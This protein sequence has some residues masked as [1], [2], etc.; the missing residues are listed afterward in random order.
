[1]KAAGKNTRGF[2]EEGCPYC[3]SERLYGPQHTRARFQQKWT[4]VQCEKSFH[5]N[6]LDK[7]YTNVDG[8]RIEEEVESGR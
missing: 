4:C 2:P 6:S 8:T 7:I 1:M 5:Y 3:S